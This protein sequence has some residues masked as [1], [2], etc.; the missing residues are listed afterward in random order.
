[1]KRR[2]GRG[3]LV[4]LLAA[5]TLFFP[6]LAAPHRI[7][8]AHRDLIRG[9]MTAAAELS[10]LATALDELTQRISGMADDA[11]AQQR[12]DIASELFEVERALAGASRRLMKVADSSER[13]TRH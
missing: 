12:D 7:D 9:G 2:L 4:I 8:Q 11:A 1:M 13:S 10:S 6:L 5:I 3:L